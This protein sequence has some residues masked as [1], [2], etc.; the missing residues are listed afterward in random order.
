MY[1]SLLKN[2]IEFQ[3]HLFPFY[4][5]E[6]I[7]KY[8]LFSG[9]EIQPNSVHFMCTTTNGACLLAL[10]NFVFRHILPFRV[11]TSTRTINCRPLIDLSNCKGLQRTGILLCVLHKNQTAIFLRTVACLISEDT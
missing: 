9:T 8:N 6:Q 11:Q 7:I 1:H 5:T 2:S 10:S 3:L 4:S